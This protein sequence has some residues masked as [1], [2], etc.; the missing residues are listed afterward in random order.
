MHSLIVLT[1]SYVY[2]SPTVEYIFYVLFNQC[3]IQ[4]KLNRIVNHMT[5]TSCIAS[6]TRILKFHIPPIKPKWYPILSEASAIA[7]KKI[8]QKA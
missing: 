5:Y 7:L 2:T 6:F 1:F 8:T 4:H 3:A